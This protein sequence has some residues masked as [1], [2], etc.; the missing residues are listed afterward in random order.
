MLIGSA[1]STRQAG[2]SFEFKPAATAYTL[3]G[4]SNSSGAAP[5]EWCASLR[6]PTAAGHTSL[7]GAEP[8]GFSAATCTLP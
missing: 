2:R 5:A 8:K 6:R 4:S 3:R 1:A 7:A